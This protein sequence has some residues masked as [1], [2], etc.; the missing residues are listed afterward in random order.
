[1]ESHG[2]AW[3]GAKSKRRL[4]PGTKLRVIVV[5]ANPVEGLIDLELG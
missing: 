5:N 1:M 4:A 2:H 3:V